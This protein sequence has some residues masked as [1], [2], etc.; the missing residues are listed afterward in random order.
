MDD[1]TTSLRATILKQHEKLYDGRMKCFDKIKKMADKVK[2]IEKHLDIVSQTHQ[3]MR[4]L[5]EKIIEL[6]EWRSTEKDI[7]SSLP[8]VKSYDIT[9][10]FMTTEECQD[11]VSR[12]EENTRKDLAGMMD[13]YG[14]STYDIQRY[15][16]WPEINFE[17]DH[18][19]P[20]TVFEQ[21][22]KKFEK[23][24][25]EVQVKN[26][27]SMEDI[28]E[29]LV[30]PSMEYSHYT[31]FV[32]KFVISTEEYKKCNIALDVKK[33]HIF[34]PREEKI[35]SQHEAW[36]KHFRKKGESKL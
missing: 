7:P 9:V 14:K 13:L 23:A 15:V 10:Y 31:T 32:Q 26:E 19:V 6:D 8:S 20:I 21:I 25:V 28:Q 1:E 35:L 2:M 29:L 16:K 17:E 4:N 22:E 11:L 12:F 36:S 18:P 27:F 3:R 5:Q 30:K 24:K 34:N 33:A